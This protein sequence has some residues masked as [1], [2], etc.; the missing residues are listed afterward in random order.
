MDHI[1]DE[2]VGRWSKDMPDGWLEIVDLEKQHIFLNLNMVG[3]YSSQSEPD[4]RWRHSFSAIL[5]NGSWTVLSPEFSVVLGQ[6]SL[7]EAIASSQ[8]PTGERIRLGF[9]DGLP[10]LPS[11]T[12]ISEEVDHATAQVGSLR[13]IF[14][15]KS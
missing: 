7:T 1:T 15:K 4:D 2:E 11:E 5:L 12:A 3:W 8:R 10:A 14:G 6:K 13:R 9:S